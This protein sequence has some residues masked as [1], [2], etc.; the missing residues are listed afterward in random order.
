MLFLFP[1]HSKGPKKIKI[2]FQLYK[3]MISLVRQFLNCQWHRR[4]NHSHP[5]TFK[6]FHELASKNRATNISLNIDRS[7]SDLLIRLTLRYELGDIISISMDISDELDDDSSNTLRLNTCLTYWIPYCIEILRRKR[8]SFSLYLNASDHGDDQHLSM[9]SHSKYNLI[10]DEYSMVESSKR[11]GNINLVEYNQFL[12]NWFKRRNVMFWRG[13]T[14]GCEKIKSIS[15]LE[16]LKRVIT[17]LKYRDYKG[18]DLSISNIV[19]YDMPKQILLQWLKEH[20]IISKPVRESMFSKYKYFPDIPGNNLFCGSWGIIRKHLSGNLVFKPIHKRKFLY[21][22]FMS[23]WD[24]YIPVNNDFSNLHDQY[25]WA[26]NHP[27]ESALI[28]WK[29]S[30]ISKHYISNIKEHFI[31][32]AIPRIEYIN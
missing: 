21:D 14:T 10:P 17:C 16:Q 4:M 9:D 19:Q 26:E 11:K 8:N 18:F 29:G 25:I 28:A 32:A 7:L 5:R 27:N 1:N 6:F 22:N 31:Q 2:A 23:P 3:L 20:R 12:R 13:S 15:N 24:H 30:T